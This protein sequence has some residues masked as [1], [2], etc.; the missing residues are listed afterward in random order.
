MEE[1]EGMG[2]GRALW[3]AMERGA[4]LHP[5]FHVDSSDAILIFWFDLL[6]LLCC[7]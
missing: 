3:T 2:M 5:K 7:C 4:E 1:R 6:L